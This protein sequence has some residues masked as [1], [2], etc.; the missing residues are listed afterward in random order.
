MSPKS[1]RRATKRRAGTPK[2]KTRK[3]G[4]KVARRMTAKSR[5][6]A[7]VRKRT[8]EPRSTPAR[9]TAAGSAPPKK[10]RHRPVRVSPRMMKLGAMLERKGAEILEQIKRAREESLDVDHTS[11]AEVGDLVSASVEKE[12]A[13]EHGEAGV[14]A[15]REIAG[16]LEKLKEGTYG[17]CE[18]CGKPIGVKRLEA[19]PHARLCVKCKIK[20]EASGKATPPPA[21][22][23]FED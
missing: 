14:H 20:E 9:K 5:R 15:L 1:V 17:I 11:F 22:T 19:M 10:T 23:A 16:A 3:A 12:K 13:F 6:P 7:A 2:R 21:E 4:A 18:R 8:S